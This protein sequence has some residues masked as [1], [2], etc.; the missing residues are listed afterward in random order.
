M[1]GDYLLQSRKKNNGPTDTHWPQLF[2]EFGCYSQCK[3]K[4]IQRVTA[5]LTYYETKFFLNKKEEEE[6]SSSKQYNFQGKSLLSFVWGG[7]GG[8][9]YCHLSCHW[10][11][12]PVDEVSF[13]EWL[14]QQNQVI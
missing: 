4:I 6:A 1:D 10:T 14:H 9:T 11:K 3:K 8:S 2:C 13:D 5:C 12:C 7:G